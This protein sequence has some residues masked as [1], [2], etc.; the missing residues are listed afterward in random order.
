VEE[1]RARGRLLERRHLRR[2]LNLHPNGGAP[3]PPKGEAHKRPRKER[4]RVF[5]GLG[6]MVYGLYWL[7]KKII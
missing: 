2:P 1:Q 6:L 3:T 5:V 4:R 7:I